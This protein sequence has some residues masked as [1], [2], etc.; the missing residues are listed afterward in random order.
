MGLQYFPRASMFILLL[1]IYFALLCV[2]YFALIIFCPLPPTIKH[3]RVVSPVP[4]Y[5][6]KYHS[7][8]TFKV[9]F[10]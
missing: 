3:G 1:K 7:R 6:V 8:V 4:I 2:S 9:K 5:K 10:Y